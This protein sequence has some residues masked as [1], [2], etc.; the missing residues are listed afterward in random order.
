[1]A[2]MVLIG[3]LDARLKLIIRD[4][5]RVS[6]SLTKG[7]YRSLAD[8]VVPCPARVNF[9]K[10]PDDRG[11]TCIFVAKGFPG[12]FVSYDKPADRDYRKWLDSVSVF[13][14]IIG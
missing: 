14:N 2:V 3:Y 9:L 7:R 10:N 13:P 5:S 12:L 4:V 6:I 1:M 8:A 11:F